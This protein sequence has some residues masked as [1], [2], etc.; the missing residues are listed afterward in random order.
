VEHRREVR[1]VADEAAGVAVRLGADRRQPVAQ[2]QR[3]DRGGL[4]V[5]RGLLDDGDGLHARRRPLVRE[6]RDA[7]DVAAGPRAALDEARADPVGDR[8][9]HDRDRRGRAPRRAGAGNAVGDEHVAP[10]ATSSSASC[11]SRVSTPSA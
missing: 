3:G 4:R 6:E 8:R 1:A 7:G 5:P 10:E 2:R 9:H 11:G